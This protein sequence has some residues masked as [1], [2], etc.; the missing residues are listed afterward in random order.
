MACQH[1]VIKSTTQ[2]IAVNRLCPTSHSLFNSCLGP[3]GVQARRS[4]QDKLYSL[5]EARVLSYVSFPVDTE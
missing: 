3:G 5:F 1:H 4:R 2:A